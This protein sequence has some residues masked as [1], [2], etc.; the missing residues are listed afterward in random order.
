MLY[1]TRNYFRQKEKHIYHLVN[2]AEKRKT[3]TSFFL[4]S[5]LKKREKIKK[6]INLKIIEINNKINEKTSIECLRL[7]NMIEI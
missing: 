5:K 7:M 3:K 4:F 2:F 6:N 1:I